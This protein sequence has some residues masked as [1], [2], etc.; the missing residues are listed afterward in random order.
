MES[1]FQGSTRMAGRKSIVSI[2]RGL[3][4]GVIGGLVGTAIMDLVLMGALSAL[5]SPA[6]TCFSIVGNTVARF[7]SIQGMELAGAIRLGVATHYIIGPLIGA[8]YATVVA[9]LKALRVN[10]LK[11]SL[12]LAILYVEI[13]SQ[14]LLAM[15]P[16][17]LKMT[18]P[19]TLQ[20]YAGSFVMHLM[21]GAALGA[22]VGLGLRLPAAEN[23]GDI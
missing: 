23:R 19:E 14:P 9:R 18:V 15:T 22:V 17:L 4:W 16:I 12:L 1:T 3:G 11:K 21:A 20:W 7:F 5:G 13:L 8:I 10:T 2:S 6:L